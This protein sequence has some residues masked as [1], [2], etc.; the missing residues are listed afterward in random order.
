VRDGKKSPV[1]IR[2]PID[3]EQARFLLSHRMSMP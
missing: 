2:A 1:D 3:Q